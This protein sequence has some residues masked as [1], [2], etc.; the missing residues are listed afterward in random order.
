MSSDNELTR[1]GFATTATG[2]LSIL[3]AL[4]AAPLA[5]QTGTSGSP[6]RA[7]DLAEWSFFWVGVERAEI[8]RGAVINAASRCTLSIRSRRA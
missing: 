7:L 8:P 5:A 4:G 3:G 1:R 2:A 6:D